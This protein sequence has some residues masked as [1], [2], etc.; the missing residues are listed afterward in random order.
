MALRTRIWVSSLLFVACS[1]E[2]RRA[3][4][5]APP[6]PRTA[7]TDVAEGLLAD[8]SAPRHPSD[9]GGRAARTGGDDRVPIATPGTWTFDF[10]AGPD[11][12]RR[13][14]FKNVDELI[15][16]I[17]DYIAA[18][19]ENPKP[20]LWTATAELILERVARLCKRTNRSPH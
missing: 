11:G 3:Q 4:E 5:E 8:L 7:L 9:G 14:V 17:D 2:A 16:A 1:G 13:G 12:I 10:E 18:N 6:F 15:T 20:F 19:N